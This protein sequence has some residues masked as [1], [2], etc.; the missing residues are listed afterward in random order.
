[1]IS[2]AFQN[3]GQDSRLL[4]ITEQGVERRYWVDTGKD[5]TFPPSVRELLDGY[6]VP[7]VM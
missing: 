4:A 5:G 1:M 2:T 7:T 3:R 6:R